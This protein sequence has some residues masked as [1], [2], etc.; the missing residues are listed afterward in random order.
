MATPSRIFLLAL[1]SSAT[2]A[3][4]KLGKPLALKQSVSIRQVLGDP[5]GHYERLASQL[6]Y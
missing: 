1:I 6:S 2:W 3:E 4:T 5:A